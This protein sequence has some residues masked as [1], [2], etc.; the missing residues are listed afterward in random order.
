MKQKERK[1]KKELEQRVL[2]TFIYLLFSVGLLAAAAAV[3][4]SEKA[5]VEIIKF[6]ENA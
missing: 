2:G 1:G 5:L 3:K 4:V 6:R